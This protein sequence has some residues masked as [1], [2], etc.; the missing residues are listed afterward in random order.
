MVI[1][2]DTEYLGATGE[3]A[4]GEFNVGASFTPNLWA[5]FDS[6]V[7]PQRGLPTHEQQFLAFVKASPF[8]ETPLESKWHYPWSEP[9]RFKAGLAPYL[10]QFYTND[11]T[12]I[13]TGRNMAWYAPFPTPVWPPNGLKFYLQRDF[14]MD[15]QWIP[16]T[17]TLL[18]GWYNWFGEPVR[19]KLGLR[20]HLQQFLAYHPRILPTPNV[21]AT[22]ASVEINEDVALIGV[23]V[24]SG[25]QPSGG[26]N[27]ANV[28]ITEVPAGNSGA[29]SIEE[30]T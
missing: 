11:T 12:P 21:T 5:P 23:W 9:V 20:A 14:T 26:V 30:E 15:A 17:G 28:S 16:S 8:P 4:V 3:F 19:E 25:S 18:E 22:W 24:Y 6:P 2:N 1:A 27:S 29:V 7:W 13:P 10:Q